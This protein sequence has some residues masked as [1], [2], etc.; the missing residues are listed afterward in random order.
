MLLRWLPAEQWWSKFMNECDAKQKTNHEVQNSGKIITLEKKSAAS[1]DKA[2]EKNLSGF[3][4]N[5]LLTMT[6]HPDRVLRGSC[7]CRWEWE[8]IVR[9]LFYNY[10]LSHLM[11]CLI[12]DHFCRVVSEWSAVA[13]ADSVLCSLRSRISAHTSEYFVAYLLDILKGVV[14]APISLKTATIWCANSQSE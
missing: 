10:R 8:W 4:S 2:E 5:D 3:S 6:Q 7:R 9:L 11:C 1:E 14:S 13:A 12:F